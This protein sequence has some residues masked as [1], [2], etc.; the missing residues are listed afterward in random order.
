MWNEFSNDP[1]EL[2]DDIME[3]I[4]YKLGYWKSVGILFAL[5]IMFRTIAFLSF[6]LLVTKF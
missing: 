3:F 2:R 6:R 4:G 5:I 1:N